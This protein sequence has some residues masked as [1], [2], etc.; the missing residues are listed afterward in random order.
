MVPLSVFLLKAIR[1]VRS[2]VPYALL[3]ILILEGFVAVGAV[4]TMPP[5][6]LLMVFVGLIT[7]GAAALFRIV[8]SLLEA[9]ILRVC[10]SAAGEG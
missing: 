9:G 1:A 4:F 2:A 8:L 5:V 6:A 3:V 7:L 10:P